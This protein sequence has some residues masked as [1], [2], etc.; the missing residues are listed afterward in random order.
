MS[1]ICAR[2]AKVFRIYFYFFFYIYVPFH[3][4][5]HSHSSLYYCVSYLRVY[6][7]KQLNLIYP[8]GWFLCELEWDSVNRTVYQ[9]IY[10]NYK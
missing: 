10:G 8:Q 6:K 4:A 1:S 9:Y 3:F 7:E 2:V 5:K